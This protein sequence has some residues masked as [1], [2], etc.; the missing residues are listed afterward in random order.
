MNVP[1]IHVPSNDLM[2]KYPLKAWR[3]IFYLHAPFLLAHI[4]S[5]SS[6]G[7]VHLLKVDESLLLVPGLGFKPE[8]K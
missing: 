1:F 5:N 4:Y 8:R 2:Q 6:L 7:V 3:A